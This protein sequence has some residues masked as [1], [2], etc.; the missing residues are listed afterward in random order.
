MLLFWTCFWT[1]CRMSVHLSIICVYS[2]FCCGV[3]VI[4]VSFFGANVTWWPLRSDLIIQTKQNISI[5][6]SIENAFSYAYLFDDVIFVSIVCV[7]ATAFSNSLIISCFRLSVP[8][9]DSSE[10]LSLWCSCITEFVVT[11]NCEIVFDISCELTATKNKYKK[12][13]NTNFLNL[14]NLNLI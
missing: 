14:L 7:I 13:F 2:P 6:F 1:F 5:Q 3:N 10:L 9:D 11:I 4:R 8:F 12:Q